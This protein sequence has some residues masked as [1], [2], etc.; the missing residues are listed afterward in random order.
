MPAV[1]RDSVIDVARFCK[2]QTKVEDR[3]TVKF[4]YLRIE[5]FDLISHM[6]MLMHESFAVAHVT[7]V[8][9]GASRLAAQFRK[10][11]HHPN[12]LKSDIRYNISFD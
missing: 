12:N 10:W 5:S 9:R 4:G 6:L 3:E 8:K 11:M 1:S 2:R 7:S